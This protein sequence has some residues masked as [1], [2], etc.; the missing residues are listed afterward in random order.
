[1][2]SWGGSC[3]IAEHSRL[4]KEA[5]EAADPDLDIHPSAEALD[6]AWICDDVLQL[7]HFDLVHLNHHDGLHSRWEARH[8]RALQEFG[9]PVVVTYHDTRESLD[10][11]PKLQDLWPVAD[12]TI[13]HEPMGSWG[14]GKVQYWRQGVPA[15]ARRP[16]QYYPCDGQFNWKDGQGMWQI[17][18]WKA[19]PQQPVLGT[20]GFNFPWKN[21]DRLAAETR[22]AGWALVLLSN[23]AT[24]EDESRW[25]QLNPSTLVVRGF[26]DGPTITNYLAGCDA[27]AYCYECANTGTSGAIRQGIAARKPVIAFESCRQ[28]RDL[29]EDAFASSMITF[30][31][32]WDDLRNTLELMPPMRY[33]AGIHALAE[34]DSWA[35]L[36]GKYADLYRQVLAGAK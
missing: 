19:F 10:D 35:R 8:V 28:F 22:E 29:S 2:T 4:L 17:Q 34:Q 21:Y 16:A 1:M 23:N 11:C 31:D 32:D 18:P 15:P 9:I 25:K 24:P 14:S 26:L 3:G 20:V 27:T 36:G 30:V 5:V 33:D 7:R 6:P 12:A 13:I